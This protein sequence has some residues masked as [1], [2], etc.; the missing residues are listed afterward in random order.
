MQATRV[1][2][3]ILST[4]LEPGLGFLLWKVLTVLLLIAYPI[5]LV[6]AYRDAERRRKDGLLLVLLVAVTWVVG[7]AVWLVVRPPKVASSA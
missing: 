4:L 6:W 5:R 1:R 2:I 3:V 7:L